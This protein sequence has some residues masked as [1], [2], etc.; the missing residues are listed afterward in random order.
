V[1]FRHKVRR[2]FSLRVVAIHSAYV[3]PL[4]LIILAVF[5][6]KYKL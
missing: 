6:E 4:D 1:T 5:S 2:Y 3:I